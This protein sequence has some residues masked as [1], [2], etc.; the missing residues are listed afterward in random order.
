M[1]G[2]SG[3][4]AAGCLVWR[5]RT[6]P[7]A[8]EGAQGTQLLR[9]YAAIRRAF[10]GLASLRLF[11]RLGRD[12]RRS[13]N[14]NR[15][16][17]APAAISTGMMTASHALA[18]LRHVVARHMPSSNLRETLA[19]PAL[20]PPGG[21]GKP[22]RGGPSFPL[23]DSLRPVDVE[24]VVDQRRHA[25]DEA[26][27]MRHSGVSLE[28]GLILP[29]RMNVEELRIANRP[30]RVDA[31][32]ARLFARRSDGG[33]QRLRHRGLVAGPR[34]KPRKDEQL[35]LM[36]LSPGCILGRMLP[37]AIG[38]PGRNLAGEGSH[39]VLLDF[40]APWCGHPGGPGAEGGDRR[41]PAGPARLSPLG[42]AEVALRLRDQTLEGGGQL[43]PSPDHARAVALQPV[44]VGRVAAPGH[45]DHEVVGLGG[46]RPRVEGEALADHLARVDLDPRRASR[47]VQRLGGNPRMLPEKLADRGLRAAEAAVVG[48]GADAG[49][50][51]TQVL[52]QE[53][54]RAADA[55]PG[56]SLRIRAQAAEAGIEP[57]PGADRPVDDHH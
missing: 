28:R 35:H 5:L 34:V 51:T 42:R 7:R 23:P 46:D 44:A 15:P 24:R 6:P 38:P 45:D 22:Y 47:S 12:D 53:A 11:G 57:D 50:G 25:L 41:P 37:S 49:Q 4:S 17:A 13:F 33:Q 32:A 18:S 2:Q 1:S 52:L 31:Q 26:H 9:P 54:Q 56:R 16:Y 19:G 20:G 3:G 30:E 10:S 21:A 14:A 8:R 29:A 43:D 36:S 27:R 40:W 48:H 39:P 55:G